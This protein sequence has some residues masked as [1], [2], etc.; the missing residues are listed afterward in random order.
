MG[1]PD[2]AVTIVCLLVIGAIFVAANKWR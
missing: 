1:W 2:A